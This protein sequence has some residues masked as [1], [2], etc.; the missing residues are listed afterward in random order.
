MEI[1][2]SHMVIYRGLERVGL[3]HLGSSEILS[4][5]MTSIG[6]LVGAI[7]FSVIMKNVL[8]TIEKWL[9]VKRVAL[10]KN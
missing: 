9:T 6:T 10:R 4:Y 2:L 3:V 7:L 1:Y 5:A 8:G